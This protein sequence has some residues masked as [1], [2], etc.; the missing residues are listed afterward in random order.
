MDNLNHIWSTQGGETAY[1]TSVCYEMALAPIPLSVAV[2]KSPLVG[3]IG[4]TAQGDMDREPLP[5]SGFGI[6]TT[7]PVV[8]K[9]TVDVNIPGWSPHIALIDEAEVNQKK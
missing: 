5:E 3:E 9:V 7:A 8:P 4:T 2:E 6:E 1:R